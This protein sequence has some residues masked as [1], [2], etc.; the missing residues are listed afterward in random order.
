MKTCAKHKQ[1]KAVGTGY[2]D[3]YKTQ[4]IQH[5]RNSFK[6]QL[7]IVGRVKI[8]THSTQIHDH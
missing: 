7:K 8:D 1:Y 5:S 3:V 6:I 4:T 2:E